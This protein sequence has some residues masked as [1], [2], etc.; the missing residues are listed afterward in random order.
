M[1]SKRWFHSWT[2]WAMGL[3]FIGSIISGITGEDWLDGEMQLTIL[4]I[5]GIILRLKTGQGLT[6]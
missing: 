6:K 1:N 3:T 4:S 2:L 5:V